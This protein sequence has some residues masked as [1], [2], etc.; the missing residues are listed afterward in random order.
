M[1]ITII[2]NEYHQQGQL[3]ALVSRCAEKRGYQVE[4]HCF[5][6]AELFS[7][8]NPGDFDLIFMDIELDG[9]DGVSAANAMRNSGF[10]GDIVFVTAFAEYVFQGYDVQALNYF[11][12]PP[13]ETQIDTCLQ[14]VHQKLRRETHIF[15]Y[16]NTIYQIPFSD[17]LYFSA[18][19]HYVDIRTKE[20][21]LRQMEALGKVYGSLPAQFLYC[22][23]TTIVNIGQVQVLRG[24]ELVLHGEVTLPVSAKYLQSIRSALLDEVNRMR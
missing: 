14:Y 13:S 7:S 24:S 19:G 16:K 3:L 10:T 6:S 17:I 9:L 8:E 20:T 23:R 15:R 11:L 12:K 5:V 1:K 4:H 22:H 18:A 21:V 2:E